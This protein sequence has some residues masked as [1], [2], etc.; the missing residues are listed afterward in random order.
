MV[1]GSVELGNR[2]D[3]EAADLCAWGGALDSR[4]SH[5]HIIQEV[6]ATDGL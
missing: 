3:H 5:G 1:I 4:V 2:E 6:E